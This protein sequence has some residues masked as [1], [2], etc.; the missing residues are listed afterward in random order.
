[1]VRKCRKKKETGS[2]MEIVKIYYAAIYIRISREE[3][4]DM[5]THKLDNQEQVIRDYIK[6][7]TDIS[8]YKVYRDNGCTGTNFDRQAF[9]QMIE[10][11]KSGAVNCIIVKDLSRLGRNH[12]ETEQYILN[13]FPFLGV[14]FIAVNDQFDSMD[15]DCDLTVSLKNIINDA[16][17]KDIS[18]KIYSAKTA[19]RIK[20]EFIG[21]IPPYGYNISE[22]DNHK[23][24][25]NEETSKAIER[26]FQLK[27]EE[28]SNTE[29]AKILNQENYEAPMAYWYRKGKVHNDK[30][31]NS[32]WLPVTIKTILRNQTYVGDMVQGKKKKCIAEGDTKVKKKDR[33]DYIVVKN[34][35]EPIIER[36]VFEQ[37]Q[38]ICEC[39]TA[40]NRDKHT[41]N[42]EMEV[43]E[44]ILEDKIFSREGLK[45]YR[46]RSI[47]PTHIAYHYVTAKKKKTDGTWYLFYYISEENLFLGLKKALYS[48]IELLFSIQ[49]MRKNPRNINRQKKEK[50]RRQKEIKEKQQ[51]INQLTEKM[52]VLYQNMAE[53]TLPL[54]KYQELKEQ[55][56]VQKDL[57]KKQLAHLEQN[58]TSVALLDNPQYMKEYRKFLEKEELNKMLIDLLVK[59]VTVTGKCQIQVT[60]LFQDEVNEIH[61]KMT[62]QECST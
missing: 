15:K 38:K 30:Y 60:F 13:I 23:L 29:I 46:G 31:K 11:V 4:L 10:D 45:M 42:Q 7:T 41:K 62:M 53:G 35:H 61:K 43:K 21:N 6:T 48:Y 26:M 19:Q 27:L 5:D 52:A 2:V 9:V 18:Q 16:Y 49:D 25:V 44:D 28:K 58:D 59:K 36:S 20:G 50:V 37:V 57:V 55:C 33:M 32:V 8:V 17:S 3:L 22:E 56:K 47:Y 51:E 14:R 54:L 12:I 24:V 34:T 39:Q 1:M 40:K